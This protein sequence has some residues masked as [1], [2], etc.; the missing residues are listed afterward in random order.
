MDT[1]TAPVFLWGVP[2]SVST[3]LEKA[4]SQHPSIAIEHEPFT[5]SYYFSSGRRSSRYQQ[6]KDQQPPLVLEAQEVSRSAGSDKIV[7]IKELAF[8]GEPY[9]SDSCLTSCRHLI[10]MR[11]PRIVYNSLLKLKPDFTEDEFGFTALERLFDRL[12]RLGRA[13][14]MTIDGDEFRE[15]PEKTLRMLCDRLDLEFD[16]MM[17]KWPS[18]KIRDWGPDEW[19]TQA[20]W[21]RTLEASNGILPLAVADE[22]R[23]GVDHGDIIRRSEEIYRRLRASRGP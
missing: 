6:P 17:L 8:Q 5:Y 9:V 13:P 3:A 20:I 18:G 7:F 14:L 2:R 15:N 16:P 11:E 19:R 21:H 4:A 1:R 23:V 10:I 12:R 22:I